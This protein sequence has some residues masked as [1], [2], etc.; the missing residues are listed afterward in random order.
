MMRMGWFLYKRPNAC[1]FISRDSVKNKTKRKE[2]QKG[3]PNVSFR[4][5]LCRLAIEMYF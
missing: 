2:V 1:I 4:L 5:V 3:K